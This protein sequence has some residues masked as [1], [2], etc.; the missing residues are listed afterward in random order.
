MNRLGHTPDEHISLDEY[1]HAM[2]VLQNVLESNQM[3]L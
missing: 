1:R 2:K 3:N